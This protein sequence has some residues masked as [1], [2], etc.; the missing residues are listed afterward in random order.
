MPPQLYTLYLSPSNFA[1]VASPLYIQPTTK[2]TIVRSALGYQLQT[3]AQGELIK[4]SPLIDAEALYRESEKA[5]SAL[6]E[7]LGEEEYFF[8]EETPGLFDASVF[9]YTNV[10]LDEGLQWKETR[11]VEGVRRFGNLV[12][13]RERILRGHFGDDS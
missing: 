5:F 6:A 9:A 3:A 7:L 10:L 13:H 2:S 11:M 4:H 1:S 8:G 12:G